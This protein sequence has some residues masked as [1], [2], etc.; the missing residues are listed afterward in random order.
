M[1]NRVRLRA[2]MATPMAAAALAAVLATARGQNPAQQPVDTVPFFGGEGTWANQFFYGTNK[3][4]VSR[5]GDWAEV[6][7]ANGRWVVIQNAQGQQFPVA[8]DAIRQFVVRWPTRIDLVAPDALVEATGVDTGTNTLQTDHLDVY[9]GASRSLVSPAMFNLFGSNRVLNPLDANQG[10]MY[11]TYF[12][13]APMEAGIPA[14]IHVVGNIL[15]L[16]PLRLGAGGNNWVNVLPSAEGLNVT[17]VTTGT[18]AYAKKGDLVYFIPDSAG[19]K[20]LTVSR[21]ILYKKI[22]LRAFAGD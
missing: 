5:Q 19:P 15:G 2:W 11:G 17:Q 18:P 6:I 10:P 1:A 3:P 7:M 12:P 8:F 13:F 9:E 14:R 21:F 4:T 20:S 22:P 16:D